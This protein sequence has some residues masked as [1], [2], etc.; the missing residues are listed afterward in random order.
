MKLTLQL[1]GFFLCTGLILPGHALGGDD[2]PDDVGDTPAEASVIAP[3]SAPTNITIEIDTD[4]DWLRFLALPGI[5]YRIDVTASTIWDTVLELRGP[6]R[7]LLVAVTNSS[8]SAAPATSSIVW[9]NNAAAGMYY[10][11]VSGFLR[12]TTGTCSI[13]VQRL[14]WADTDGDGLPDAWEMA[15]LGTLAWGASDDPDK[16]GASNISEY[17]AMTDPGNAG[18]VLRILSISNI[19]SGVELSWPCAP[20]A[21]YCITRTTNLVPGAWAPVGT[22]YHMTAVFETGQWLDPLA[23]TQGMYRVE[24][25]LDY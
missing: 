5:A 16:D 4:A 10:F 9:T 14:N 3:D 11:G 1:I 20:Y 22:N 12:F 25:I 8:L 18:S 23:G 7:Q 6:D 21:G 2:F 13:A 19:E 15:K 24:Q 17:Y